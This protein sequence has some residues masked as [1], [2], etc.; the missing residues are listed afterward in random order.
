MSKII[1]VFL[2]TLCLQSCFAQN[3]IEVR[4]ENKTDLI[5]DNEPAQ[6]KK[7]CY[8]YFG[9]V[10]SFAIVLL[11]QQKEVSF[12]LKELYPQGGIPE[13]FRVDS[14]YVLISGNVLRCNETNRCTPPTPGAGRLTTNMLELKSI[15]I[16]ER[17]ECS[18]CDDT[19]ILNPERAAL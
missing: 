5:L 2:V 11:H 9:K 14:L 1:A 16:N 13:K 4:C 3:H 7:G 12:Y 10:D 19:N 15:E 8:E 17:G 6:I 18:R